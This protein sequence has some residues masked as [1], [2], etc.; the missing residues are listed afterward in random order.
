MDEYQFTNELEKYRVVR[1]WDYQGK[2]H[3]KDPVAFNQQ[4]AKLQE[5]RLSTKRSAKS[6]QTPNS[7]TTTTTATTSTTTPSLSGSSLGEVITLQVKVMKA[8]QF[9]IPA[10]IDILLDKISKNESILSLKYKITQK[11]PQIPWLEFFPAQH[12]NQDGLKSTETGM[13]LLLKGKPLRDEH[14][15]SHYPGITDGCKLSVMIS[16]INSQKSSPSTSENTTEEVKVS[17]WDMLRPA[18]RKDLISARGSGA[19]VG[20]EEVGRVYEEV[21]RMYDHMIQSMSLDDIERLAQSYRTGDA[22]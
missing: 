14:L 13:K 17:F 11:L 16:K 6:N 2:T 19:V 4:H 1:N 10:A 5:D 21:K 9:K 3:L 18:I 20:E 8:S 22:V 12:D 15:L 7:T